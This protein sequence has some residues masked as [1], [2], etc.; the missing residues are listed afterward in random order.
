M[1]HMAH[2]TVESTATAVVH[3]SSSPQTSTAEGS[4]DMTASRDSKPN[5]A[6]ATKVVEAVGTATVPGTAQDEEALNKALRK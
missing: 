1:S 5:K 6:E 3:S 2:V 4:C